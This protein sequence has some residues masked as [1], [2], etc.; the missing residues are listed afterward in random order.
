MSTATQAA[1]N[2]TGKPVAQLLDDPT[3][4]Q[5]LVGEVL[6]NYGARNTSELVESTGL[7]E[8]TVRSALKYLRAQDRAEWK[9]TDDARVR[10]HYWTGGDD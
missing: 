10:V 9:L 4:S 3:G 7:S 6:R 5:V 8:P 2:T 1:R